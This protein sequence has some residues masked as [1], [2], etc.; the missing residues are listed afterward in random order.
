MNAAGKP[1][2]W[3][4]YFK[5]SNHFHPFACEF[6]NRLARDGLDGLLTLDTQT[7][8]NAYLHTPWH[9]GYVVPASRAPSG[10]LIHV[11]GPQ[12]TNSGG[13]FYALVKDGN[14]LDLH[15]HDNSST[16]NPWQRVGMI[17]DQVLSPGALV[18]VTE[19]GIETLHALVSKSSGVWHFSFKVDGSSISADQLSSMASYMGGGLIHSDFDHL[20]AVVLEGRI[21]NSEG[22]IREGGKLVHYWLDGQTWQSAGTISEDATGPGSLIQSDY[23]RGGNGDFEVVVPEGPRLV[24][25]SKD[26]NAGD[27]RRGAVV[28][29]SLWEPQH[30]YNEGDA[31]GPG[32]L[33]QS[34][35]R[36]GWHGNYEVVVREGKKGED[37]VHYWKDNSTP[38]GPWHR[39][40][41]ITNGATSPGSIVHGPWSGNL[42]VMVGEGNRVAH[43][44]HTTEGDRFYFHDK[45]APLEDAVEEPFPRHDVEF[46]GLEAYSQY[47]WEIFFHVPML[48]ATTLADNQRFDEATRWFHFVFEPTTD[49]KESGTS[50]FWK[51]L[52]F[53]DTERQRI[54]DFL[55]ALNGE[56]SNSAKAKQ[57][58]EWRK[59]PFDPH[60]IA[61]MRLIA[62]Q[63][64]VVMKYLDHKIAKADQR[65]RDARSL[66]DLNAATQD[67]VVA[68]N[69]LGPQPQ[70]V[71]PR[72]RVAAQ[73]FEELSN[74]GLDAFSNALIALENEAPFSSLGATPSTPDAARLLGMGH[75]LFFCAPRN[76]KLLSYWDTVSDRLFKLR[77]CMS[78]EGT[79]LELPLFE[80]AIDPALLVQAAAKGL[81][82]GTVLADLSGPL[83]KYRFSFVL[84]KALEFCA[85]V[86]AYGSAVLT[87]IE[88]GEAE[89]LAAMRATHEV[90]MLK[91]LVAVK[92]QQVKETVAAREALEQSVPGIRLRKQFYEESI[93]E[94]GR[95]TTGKEQ[96]QQS[97]LSQA[98]D[99]QIAAQFAEAAAI[100]L[101]LI[102][103]G[104]SM[105]TGT[106]GISSPVILTSGGAHYGVLAAQVAGR[107]F[108]YLAGIHSYRAAQ[109]GNEAVFERHKREWQLQLDLAS[110]EQ[111]QID[112]QILAAQIHEQIAQQ[113]LDNQLKQMEESEQVKEFLQTK[114]TNAELYSWMRNETATLFFQ[115]YRLAYDLAKQAERAFRFERG[116]T[117]SDFIQFG[118]WDN[119]HSGLMAGE[120]LHLALKQMEKAY[121]DQNRRDYEISKDI[122][123]LRLDPLALITLKETGHCEL[124]LPE[125]LFDTD[126]PGHFMRRMKSASITIPCVVGPYTSVNCTLTLLNSTIRK[127]AVAGSGGYP[128]QNDD[129]RFLHDFAA[130]QSIATSHA[131]GDT[132]MF[133]LNFRDERYLP[134][135]GA[136]AISRWRIDMPKDC[137]GF[138]FDTIS[139]LI[140][141]LNYTARDGGAVLREAA[142]TQR[143]TILASAEPSQTRLFSARHEFPN[144]WQRFLHPADETVTDQVFE[145][146]FD[147][148]R[149]PFL[150]RGKQIQLKTLNVF[151]KFSDKPAKA[152]SAKTFA[153]LYY[154]PG[155]SPLLVSVVV[156]GQGTPSSGTITLQANQNVLHGLG[157]GNLPLSNQV[158]ATIKLTINQSQ[159]SA[160]SADFVLTNASGQKRLVPTA[161]EDLL[162]LLEY[163][164]T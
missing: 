56:G 64:H 30:A 48:L 139:D 33:I 69:I 25:Y 4:H 2:A 82:I 20:E 123:V 34:R 21:L 84:Q 154:D 164:I 81:D 37:L 120:R 61:G 18:L 31:V 68:K 39:G 79:P 127:D 152:G 150:F 35:I 22:R 89:K 40:R 52:P 107:A 94:N 87:A 125:V 38:N 155:A 65:F 13:Y 7:L 73:T 159:L 142:K 47:N 148:D 44:W 136:G 3:K 117:S 76:D 138:D 95:G 74:L 8:G 101:A 75:S 55:R 104:Q 137:N 162:L 58:D 102:P 57:V 29:D 97:Q 51:V 86:R 88:K 161:A 141:R 130:V 92:E 116:L 160:L 149:F 19:G 144:E 140:L 11:A 42:E 151:M 156:S 23:G 1:V 77:H 132:G 26:N 135:E 157:I 115:S 27:W 99:W 12:G 158:P 109:S 106:A 49:V 134:F 153:E 67:Y 111:K 24:H 14:K 5:F 66:E 103:V 85:D 147:Q 6:V 90:Q 71:T 59:H 105:I 121:L 10:T 80:P 146:A 98:A 50:R 45:Y 100:P 119:L 113:D 126:Y 15:R 46:S 28:T 145:I 163:S 70:R 112:K 118:Y 72:G 83:P 53:R 54:D 129:V 32:A 143:N 114:Y 122:S 108:G 36:D 62:Y 93:N 16:A 41:V 43:Y 110:N 60:L 17:T 133:E 128:E 63:K 124:S 9:P 96:D 78:I 91:R 131:Q